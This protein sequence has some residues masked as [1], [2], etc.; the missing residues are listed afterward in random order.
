MQRYLEQA[1]SNVVSNWALRRA[2]RKSR[3]ILE[4]TRELPRSSDQ[5]IRQQFDELRW[6][7]ISGIHW[8]QILPESFALVCEAARRV[9][10][11]PHFEVQILAG[12]ALMGGGIAEMQTGE[13]KTLAALLPA[14]LRGLYGRGCHVVTANDYLAKRDAAFARPVFDLLG[15]SVGC[16]FDGLPREAR[17]GEYACDVTYG[18]AREFGFDFLRDTL[19]A[20]A[21]DPPVAHPR[22]GG[23]T[24]ATCGVQRGHDFALVDEADSVLLDDARTPLLIATQKDDAR[25][26]RLYQW[27]SAAADRLQ[28]GVDFTIDEK[29]LRARLSQHGT[30]QVLRGR[31]VPCTLGIDR[32]RLF[33]QVERSLIARHALC[34][35]RDYV[36]AS[37]GVVIVDSSTGRIADGRK[38]QDGLHQAVEAKEGLAPS[39]V[40]STAARVTIQSYFRRYTHLAGLTGTARESR[41]ELRRIY[42]LGVVTIPTRRPC[43]R[44]ELP[45]R[46]FVSQEAKYRQVIHEVRARVA[47]GGA[48]LVGTPSVRAS[49][50]LSQV[51]SDNGIEHE[52]LNCRAHARESE[53]IARA[54]QSGRVTVATNMAGRGTDIRVDA[55]V[56]R[57]GGLHV[58]ATEMHATRRTDRQ[59]IGRTARQGDPGTYQFLLSLEDE[60]LDRLPAETTRRLRDQARPGASGELSPDALSTFRR[61]QRAHERQHERQR[62]RLSREDREHARRCR[63]AGLNSVT[64]V[65]DP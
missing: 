47:A 19:E 55:S 2:R 40:T 12:I 56:L 3:Q 14:F 29:S 60:L 36:V 24:P 50:T 46:V 5:A 57:A 21:V 26:A 33:D 28:A 64:E 65:I 22:T 9:H 49:E 43:V 39:G 44:R 41:H 59:L 18:T 53:I 23:I 20:D 30:H 54:G 16:I 42:G 11:T 38:W 58:I 37:E 1:I 32:Q 34:R 51:L 48:V 45:P 4:S 61:A 25:D 35:D 15:M 62:K 52:V 27:S 10:G 8:Q 17:S 63:Q 6:R 7:A 13:G 31:E